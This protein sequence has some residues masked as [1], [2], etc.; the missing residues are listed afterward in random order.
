MITA[1]TILPVATLSDTAVRSASLLHMALLDEF[2]RLT[3]EAAGDEN[4]GFVRD[5]LEETLAALRV[6]RDGYAV[7]LH[8][9][10]IMPQASVPAA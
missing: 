9:A 2:I 5:S 1:A 10:M 7:V 6:E 3:R 8:G 4:D